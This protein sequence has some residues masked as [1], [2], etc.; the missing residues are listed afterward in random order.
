VKKL[1]PLLVLAAWPALADLTNTNFVASADF[2]MADTNGL[3]TSPGPTSFVARVRAVWFADG[4]TQDTASAS[5]SNF[6]A[7]IGGALSGNATNTAAWMYDPGEGSDWHVY[8]SLGGATN[9]TGAAL[10]IGDDG[11]LSL[12]GTD[13]DG[14]PSGDV[15]IQAGNIV[16]GNA[17]GG[18]DLRFEAGSW[19]GDANAGGHVYVAR[20]DGAFSGFG[21][22]SY[23]GG[24]LFQVSG[25][26]SVVG[27]STNSILVE[28]YPLPV[29]SMTEGTNTTSLTLATNTVGRLARLRNGSRF[30]ILD[31]EDVNPSLYVTV[32][33]FQA[34]DPYT[35][36]WRKVPAA[37]KTNVLVLIDGAGTITTQRVL[38]VTEQ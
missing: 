35:N 24:L 1:I 10:T 12:K 18:Y 30:Q 31:T 32:A 36:A 17:R 27:P 28:T 3:S 2:V 25:R 4:T 13:G 21:D 9:Q 29:F 38:S 14:D 16:S 6:L 37:S 7:A 34:S 15:R 33:S 11:T 8:L 26:V 5:S 19:V 20:R 22:P 23:D